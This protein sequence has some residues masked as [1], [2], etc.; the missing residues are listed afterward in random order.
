MTKKIYVLGGGTVFHVRP[1]FALSA[2][3]YGK[4]A[5][6]IAAEL[7]AKSDYEV[8]LGLT[9]MAGT[10]DVENF[11]S[12]GET[13]HD[14]A[15]FL[16]KIVT[17][18]DTKMIFMSVAL[19]DFEGSVGNFEG[20]KFHPTLSGKG[21][22]R[23]KT[24][25]GSQML[26][27]TPAQKLI[28]E[29]RKQRKDIFLVG[30]KTTAGENEA[31]TYEKGLEL[32]KKNSCNLVV[33]NDVQTGLNM[34]IAPELAKYHV[35]SD[36][37]E[38]VKGLVEIALSRA[39][40]EF[41]RTQILPGHLI[42]WK[43]T[44]ETLQKV[45][46]WAVEAG[47]YKAFN[48]VTVGHFGYRC[49]GEDSMLGGS[50]GVIL[51]SSRRK[52]NFNLPEC[53]DLVE[54]YFTPTSQTAYGA[55]PSAGARSQF[56]VLSKYEDLDCII[57][58]HCPM[59]AGSEVPVREQRMFECGSHQCGKNTVDGLKRFGNSIAAVMLSKHGPNI[60]FSRDADPQEVIK[61]IE[62]NFDLT[63]RTE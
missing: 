49:R 38:L 12:L 47:G 8:H 61:F 14:V 43:E 25:E 20:D 34:I 45:V 7:R 28:G 22:P 27:L 24:S 63:R 23:L 11:H 57:H 51:R 59:K 2:P 39:S 32:L 6:S 31:V 26:R 36:R 16:E 15:L 58:F 56:V 62:D 60:V 46:D 10:E 1:H 30:F 41:S 21:Q 3:A 13:N 42:P 53:R 35:T 37:K 40:N 48:N 4:V 17:D 18:P 50:P 52:Q 44:P 55:K 9:K 19:C 33:G 54:V 5:R 29:I